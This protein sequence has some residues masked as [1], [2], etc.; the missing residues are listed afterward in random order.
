MI[1]LTTSTSAQQLSV[2]P[3]VYTSTFTMT[4]R[5]DSTNVLKKY[6]V[7]T[8]VTSGNYLNFNQAFNPVLVEGHFFDLSLFVDYNF[9]NTN[10]SLW[11]L[12]NVLWNVDGDVTED[13]FNDRIF[14]T[15]Q[16]VNQ[17]NNNE[18]YKLNLGQYTEYNG[19]DNTYTVR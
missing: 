2:I 17:L 15:D 12:Y 7:S 14:C 19:F 9:W 13:I 18:R 6:D 5:D 16:D 1:I 3:R 10:N 11:N 8:A 4:I